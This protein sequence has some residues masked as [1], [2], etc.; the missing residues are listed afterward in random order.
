MI[1]AADQ[2][3]AAGP[4][5]RAARFIGLDMQLFGRAQAVL[6]QAAASSGS[7]F[8]RQRLGLAKVSGEQFFDDFAMDVCQAEISTLK[9]VGQFFMIE[10]QQMHHRCLEVMDVYW[11]FGNREAEF[12]T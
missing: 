2:K 7:S 3:R 8:V 9:K 4:A 12:I 11:I 6:R 1:R 5:G 10:S